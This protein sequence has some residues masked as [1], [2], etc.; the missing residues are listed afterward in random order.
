MGSNSLQFS[1]CSV[2]ILIATFVPKGSF[3]FNPPAIEGVRNEQELWDDDSTDGSIKSDIE[4]AR[5]KTDESEAVP[6]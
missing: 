1:I 3:A 5:R 6:R 2:I 4:G